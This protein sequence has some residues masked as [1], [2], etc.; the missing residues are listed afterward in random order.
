MKPQHLARQA[1]LARP[2]QEIADPRTV[3]AIGLSER[4]GEQKRPLAFPEIAVDFLAVS[5]NVPFEVQNIV[6]DLEG[7]A[8]QTAQAIEPTKVALLAIGDE[9]ANPH[10][11]NEAVPSGL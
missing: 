5:R 6:G 8:E 10:R 3:R 2:R 9:R 11:V 7:K 1:A 4:V